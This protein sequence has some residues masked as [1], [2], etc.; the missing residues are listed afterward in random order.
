MF[1]L[2]V[3][4]FTFV[5]WTSVTSADA[6][7]SQV[8][9][10]DVQTQGVCNASLQLKNCGGVLNTARDD[11]HAWPSDVESAQPLYGQTEEY[12]LFAD[13]VAQ[14]IRQVFRDSSHKEIHLY[15]S[16][17]PG[18]CY[19][20]LLYYTCASAYNVCVEDMNTTVKVARQTLSHSSLQSETIS[21]TAA[22][23]GIEIIAEPL[24]VPMLPCFSYCNDSYVQYCKDKL[25]MALNTSLPGL[26]SLGQY[27]GNIT[28]WFNCT[29]LSGKSMYSKNDATEICLPRP[30]DPG[31]PDSPPPPHQPPLPPPPPVSQARRKSVNLLS[32]ACFAHFQLLL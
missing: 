10:A 15:D 3:L 6:Q 1:Y 31:S 24:I 23:S 2:A 16:R 4:F 28:G 17:S 19:F 27:V 20:P 26:P 32:M 29:S 22:E 5:C 25:L 30:K 14:L 21:D 18:E 7:V 8:A 11:R 12:T 13:F 9:F